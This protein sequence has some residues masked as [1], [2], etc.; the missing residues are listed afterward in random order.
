MDNFTI[1]FLNDGS[2]FGELNS[3]IPSGLNL[4]MSTFILALGELYAIACHGPTVM[5]IRAPRAPPSKT[6]SSQGIVRSKSP[7]TA[8][9]LTD[10][11]QEYLLMDNHQIMMMI[12]EHLPTQFKNIKTTHNYGKNNQSLEWFMFEFIGGIVFMWRYI[13]EYLGD[14]HTFYSRVETAVRDVKRQKVLLITRQMDW[15]NR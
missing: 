9:H 7:L 10:K 3:T 6:C 11:K 15:S 5:H 1:Y 13:E 14:Y 2:A 8:T 12:S 4:K